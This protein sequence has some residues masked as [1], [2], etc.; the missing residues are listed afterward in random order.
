M[1]Q[2]SQPQE[3]RPDF[4]RLRMRIT[5]RATSAAT[6]ARIR[7]SQ[8]FMYFSFPPQNQPVTLPRRRIPNAAT[9]AMAHCQKTT[10]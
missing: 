9:Q 3:Q 6:A 8:T 1:P 10:I 4:F 2:P 7:I 5:A